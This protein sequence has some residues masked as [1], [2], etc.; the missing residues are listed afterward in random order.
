MHRGNERH[1]KTYDAHVGRV[2]SFV[3][4]NLLHRL[5]KAVIKAYSYITP[6]CFYSP[7]SEYH[8][9]LN[10]EK[11]AIIHCLEHKQKKILQRHQEK[12]HRILLL[13]IM[14][15]L[16]FLKHHTPANA[17]T[18]S[19]NLGVSATI[20]AKCRINS[21]LMAFGSYDPDSNSNLNVNGNIMMTCTKNTTSSISLNDGVNSSRAEGTTRAMRDTGGGNGNR[22]YL[23][24]EL[25]KNS[26]RTTVWSTSNPLVVTATSTATMNIPLY[27]TIPKLQNVKK[28]GYV[29]TVLITV[30]F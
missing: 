20:T 23:S 2:R 30:N 17:S 28:G 6:P 10:E 18:N 11:E 26:N 12:H 8:F 5:H 7:G 21:S 3:F 24:Y 25:Y 4:K 9:S 22:D 19:A 1:R 14:S 16:V 27:G 29:D 15:L 13:I